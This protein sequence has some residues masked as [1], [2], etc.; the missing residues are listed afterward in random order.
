MWY[1]L[2]IDKKNVSYKITS[3][4]KI[5]NDILENYEKQSKEEPTFCNEAIYYNELYYFSKNKLALERKIKE[6]GWIYS[7][8]M[9]EM[10]LVKEKQL[11]VIEQEANL[12]KKSILAD[13]IMVNKFLKDFAKTTVYNVKEL[14]L[15]N[16]A[17]LKITESGLKR[18]IKNLEL[19]VES[20]YSSVFHY[21]LD[22]IINED[23]FHYIEGKNWYVRMKN[24]T[25]IINPNSYTIINASLKK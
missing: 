23:S 16:Q 25:L 14:L 24:I 17:E 2:E 22:L 21:C 11:N 7:K 15:A 3:P 4:K 5:F 6:L 10:I 20:N 1:Q 18:I 8:Q 9:N 13:K 19:D 12:I